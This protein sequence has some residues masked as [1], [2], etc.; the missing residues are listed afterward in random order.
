MAFETLFY[1][2]FRGGDRSRVAAAPNSVIHGDF[3]KALT[4]KFSLPNDVAA[5]T[6]S[7]DDG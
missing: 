4:T 5:S 3:L 2:V 1:D 6:K 7:A